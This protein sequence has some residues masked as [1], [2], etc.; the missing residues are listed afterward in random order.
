MRQIKT[1]T[2]DYL[3]Q[4]TLHLISALCCTLLLLSLRLGPFSSR[5]CLSAPAILW[6]W[7]GSRSHQDTYGWRLSLALPPFPSQLSFDELNAAVM[8]KIS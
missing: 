2:T 1:K 5:G 6:W 7:G 8:S 3:Y 4:S